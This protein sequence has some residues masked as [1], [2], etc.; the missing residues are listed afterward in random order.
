MKNFEELLMVIIFMLF[1]M[2]LILLYLENNSEIFHYNI[3]QFW[4]ILIFI[5]NNINYRANFI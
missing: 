3:Q 5:K 1:I 2:L 4:K